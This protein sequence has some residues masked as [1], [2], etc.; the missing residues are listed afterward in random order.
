MAWARDLARASLLILALC[1]LDSRVSPGMSVTA[2]LQTLDHDEVNT[3][4]EPTGAISKKSPS[5][6]CA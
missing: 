2:P 4:A 5:R 6:S 1:A 3:P